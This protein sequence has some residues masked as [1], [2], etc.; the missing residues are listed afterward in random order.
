MSENNG[1][2]NP[3]ESYRSKYPKHIAYS[4]GY[5]LVCVDDKFSKLFKTYL[6]KDAVFNFGNSMI[7]EGKFC[8]EVMKKN[9]IKNM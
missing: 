4:Y 5:K 8:R 1:Q 2:Q 9:V 6:G 3:E 7:Q